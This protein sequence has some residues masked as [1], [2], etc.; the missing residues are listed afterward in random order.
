MVIEMKVPLPAFSTFQFSR[1]L[2][3]LLAVARRWLPKLN[4]PYDVGLRKGT[5]ASGKS[6]SR[7]KGECL[8]RFMRMVG[9]LLRVYLL[10]T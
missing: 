10:N 7:Q 9:V 2:A 5:V 4:V 6:R 3:P 8:R 1:C